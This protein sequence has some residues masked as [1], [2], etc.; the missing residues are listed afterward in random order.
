L[1]N[2]HRKSAGLGLKTWK[3]GMFC[4][5]GFDFEPGQVRETQ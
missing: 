1:W 3:S 2:I 5:K 4:G